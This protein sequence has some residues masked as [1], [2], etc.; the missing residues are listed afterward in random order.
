MGVGS[1]LKVAVKGLGTFLFGNS[2]AGTE[3]NFA[4]KA[5]TGIGTWID[6][7]TFT[8]EEK[9]KA[10]Q[11]AVETVL[12]VYKTDAAGASQ[13]SQARRQMMWL[14]ARAYILLIMAAAIT[15]FASPNGGADF[16]L[17]LAHETY[18]GQITWTAAGFYFLTNLVRGLK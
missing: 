3:E 4:Q 2:K 5:A 16:L 1:I 15:Y 17:K 6:E 10:N 11:Q 7:R 9:A 18:I 8:E 13:R 12:E 14:F